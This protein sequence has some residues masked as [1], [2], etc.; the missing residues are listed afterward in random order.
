MY[1]N[2]DEAIARVEE[3]VRRAQQRAARYPKLQKS[4][5]GVRV[6][7]VSSR[8]DLA[9]EVREH[10]G[11][12]VPGAELPHAIG[13]GGAQQAAI[14]LRRQPPGEAPAVRRLQ[15]L[16]RE[17]RRH[18]VVVVRRPHLDHA[19]SVRFVGT[20]D[21]RRDPGHAGGG[22]SLHAGI[23]HAWRE[24]GRSRSR[25]VRAMGAP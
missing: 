15:P 21:R 10:P 17:H 6:R 2:P 24:E 14:L 11:R 12:D 18:V 8:R 22:G 9:V 1:E 7:V 3:D 4:I 25:L 5:D 20:L 16:R 13:P 23:E 19:A